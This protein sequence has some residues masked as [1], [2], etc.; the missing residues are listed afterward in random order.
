MSVTPLVARNKNR[1]G[2]S[3]INLRTS[4][5]A[6]YLASA[7]CTLMNP[8]DKFFTKYSRLTS[9]KPAPAILCWAKDNNYY[10]VYYV[11]LGNN[12]LSICY[13]L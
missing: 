7:K 4:R 8:T 1:S 11:G 2:G 3:A 6:G 12:R 13:K 9:L 10:W 5:H